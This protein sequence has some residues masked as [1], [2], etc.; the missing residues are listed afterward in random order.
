M[1]HLQKLKSLLLLLC[2][3]VTA[4]AQLSNGKVYNFVNV[5]NPGKSMTSAT[6]GNYLSIATTDQTDYSQLWYVASDGNGIT[7]RN[8]GNGNYLRSPNAGG[9]T[10]WTL[11]KTVDGNNCRF[12][13]TQESG[14]D[15]L[16]AINATDSYHYMH[17]GATTGT[18]VCWTSSAP[19]T[20]WDFTEV[21]NITSAQ[22]NAN[23]EALAAIN[24]SDATIGTYQT[25]LDNL[26]SDKACTTLKK[27][28]ANE[29]AV[30]N[31]ADYKA[32]PTTL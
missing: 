6:A 24:P 16:R 4:Q 2:F 22:L 17:Y 12:S 19:A 1:Y 18:V 23:W 30:K 8:L 3:A 7:L 15:V 26:F 27:S 31:D 10:N 32:L 5:G 14:H 28:F 13:C 29:D 20:Q 25:A 9:N 21:T 11:V